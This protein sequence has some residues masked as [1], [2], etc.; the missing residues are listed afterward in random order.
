[1]PTSDTCDK[2]GTSLVSHQTTSLRFRFAILALVLLVGIMLGNKELTTLGALCL[3]LERIGIALKYVINIGRLLCIVA[4]FPFGCHA[5]VILID[6]EIHCFKG[7]HSLHRLREFKQA[8]VD[9]YLESKLNSQDENGPG[10][11]RP[12]G[13]Y[14]AEENDNKESSNSSQPQDSEPRLFDRFLPRNR[15]RFK[16]IHFIM[17]MDLAVAVILTKYRERIDLAL[18]NALHTAFWRLCYL[19]LDPTFATFGGLYL[20]VRTVYHDLIENTD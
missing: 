1:M 4:F 3:A 16:S 10:E 7:H 19:L 17:A 8:A 6:L 20:L 5:I 11:L 12:D 15:F 2:C 18:H 14:L 9:K 13:T